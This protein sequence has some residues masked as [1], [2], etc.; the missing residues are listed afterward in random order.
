[1]F[2]ENILNNATAGTFST[3]GT[4]V[5]SHELNNDTMALSTQFLPQINRAFKQVT[6]V[7][8]CQNNTQPYLEKTYTYPV[9]VLSLCL[10]PGRLHTSP[11]VVQRVG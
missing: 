7:G 10:Y 2:Q 4:I 11:L 5:L 8:V 9:G 6:P 1:L 3:H